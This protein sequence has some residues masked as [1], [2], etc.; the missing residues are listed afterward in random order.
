M[1]KFIEDAKVQ[2]KEVNQVEQKQEGKSRLDGRLIKFTITYEYEDKF[3]KIKKK[4]GLI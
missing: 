3:I 1:K 2:K 4:I